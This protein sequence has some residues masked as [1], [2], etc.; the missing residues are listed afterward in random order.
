[1]D[2]NE[3]INKMQERGYEAEHRSDGYHDKVVISKGIYHVAIE[4]IHVV[5]ATFSYLLNLVER[6]MNNLK[7]EQNVKEREEAGI[8][9]LFDERLVVSGAG[10]LGKD[11]FDLFTLVQNMIGFYREEF[12]IRSA[13]KVVFSKSVLKVIESHAFEHYGKYDA[14]EIYGVKFD[15]EENP[16]YPIQI[17]LNF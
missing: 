7:Q 16:E 15:V 3:F 11:G 5:T 12:P 17:T 8:K 2:L 14:T 6:T 1:M 10:I 4:G 9:F 13:I